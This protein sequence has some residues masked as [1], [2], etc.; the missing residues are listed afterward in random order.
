VIVVMV[1]TWTILLFY[2]NLPAWLG[3]LNL[4]D[5]LGIFIYSMSVNFLESLI[6][7]AGICLFSLILPRRLFLDA[8]VARGA[9]LAALVLGLM[10]FI[11]RQ[12]STKQN[13]GGTDPVGSGVPGRH[14]A[15]RLLP[16]K[17]WIPA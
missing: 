1:Y 16:G 15:G 17:N 6:V 12:F 10:M 3:F 11:A 7:L 5:I 4:G 13:Y 14:P 8:F 2:Y 9:G